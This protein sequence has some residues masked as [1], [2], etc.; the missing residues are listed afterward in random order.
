M[1]VWLEV[2]W[3]DLDSARPLLIFTEKC[4]HTPKLIYAYGVQYSVFEY[5]MEAFI[6]RYR[7]DFG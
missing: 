3:I 5:D 2:R 7:A 1:E 6:P 4:C